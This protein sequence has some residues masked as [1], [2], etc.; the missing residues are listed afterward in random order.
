MLDSEGKIIATNAAW[1][2]L[3]KENGFTDL[4]HCIGAPYLAICD[5]ALGQPSASSRFADQLRVLLEGDREF[6]RRTFSCNHAGEERWYQVSAGR[7]EV[8][9]E[10]R[11]VIAHEDV[12]EVTA[13]R[14]ALNN[15][16]RR[17]L[18]QQEEERRRI[19]AELHNSTA[20]HL[21]AIG[22]NMARLLKSKGKAVKE[23]SCEISLSLDQALKE[24]RIF[25]YL[26]HP[27][28]LDSEG[29]KATLEEFVH[30]FGRRTGLAVNMWASEAIDRLPTDLQRTILRVVQE[31][32]LNTHRH[33]A[34]TGVSVAVRL[35]RDT[36][37]L[38]ISDNGIGLR[39]DN[40]DE[41]TVAKVAL[42][43][44]IPGMRVRVQEFGGRLEIRSGKKGT[45]I[46]ASVP[47]SAIDQRV[48]RSARV[49]RGAAL[50][51]A[52][53]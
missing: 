20:Q 19:A 29:L 43:V 47:L 11:I 12:T 18:A 40:G 36:L 6:V 21:V 38:R 30:G 1:D 34:A 28:R 14:A 16:P 39:S 4:A 27:P 52:F 46:L 32:L 2:H 8:G 44:G 51:K 48:T 23:I 9:A 31:G 3:V 41:T 50:D 53:V 10:A 22:L 45:T 35:L 37:V 5:K 25:S 24:I 49:T 26:L 13:A 17:L 33:A 42:G 15:V 7:F